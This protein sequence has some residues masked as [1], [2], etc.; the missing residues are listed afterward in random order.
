MTK[1][2]Q[3]EKTVKNHNRILVSAATSLFLLTALDASPAEAGKIHERRVHQKA[4]IAEGVGDN[5]VSRGE[6][7]RLRL[8]QRRIG[9]MARRMRA[10]DG[11][12]GRRERRKLTRLQKRASHHIF[13][14][15]HNHRSAS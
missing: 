2:A 13:R 14:A 11:K 9:R 10:D 6:A 1:I 4:R 5:T 3:G 8:E 12:L 15:R 7:R